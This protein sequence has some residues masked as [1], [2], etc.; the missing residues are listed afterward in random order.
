MK[1]YFNYSKKKFDNRTPIQL[2]NE[3]FISNQKITLSLLPKVYYNKNN[4]TFP[5]G[6]ISK[7]KTIYCN[8]NGYYSIYQSDRYGFN[9]PDYE[10]DKPK[11]KFLLL[12]D[13][14]VHGACVNRPNDIASNLRNI[15]KET[16]LNLGYKGN[17]PLMQLAAYKEY[18]FKNIDNV[19]WFY[20][21][22]DVW[23]LKR[24][25]DNKFLIKYLNNKNFTQ[26]LKNK[27]ETIDIHIRKELNKILNKKIKKNTSFSSEIIHIIKFIKMENIRK[28]ILTPEIQNEFYE[29]L[30]LAQKITKKNNSNIYFVYLPSYQNIKNNYY[31]KNFDK[32]KKKL[33]KLEIPLIDIKKELFDKLN[34]PINLFP[35]GFNGHYNE[36]GYK[37]VAET[38]NLLIKN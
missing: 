27:Q 1:K 15:S 22:N 36:E 10:W 29:I 19:I 13:S 7:S 6:N 38:L 28:I 26:N 30:E 33:N 3:I 17:G 35:F 25:L 8:E 37:K 12:G 24:E 9:N 32:I 20:F 34:E 11:I 23:D 21:E 4:E 31:Y 2:F 14:F 16:V 18:N 5:L